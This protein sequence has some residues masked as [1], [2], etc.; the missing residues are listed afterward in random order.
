MVPAYSYVPQKL[1]SRANLAITFIL[2]LK[3]KVTSIRL[4]VPFGKTWILDA[5]IFAVP[6]NEKIALLRYICK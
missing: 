5:V 4:S 6:K 3:L 1:S 2:Q